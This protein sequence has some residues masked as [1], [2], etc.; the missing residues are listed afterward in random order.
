[1]EKK[2]VR[3]KNTEH[4]FCIP[5]NASHVEQRVCDRPLVAL[6]VFW[7]VTFGGMANIRQG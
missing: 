2:D 7:R 4:I 1:M 3:Q 5:P 6:E